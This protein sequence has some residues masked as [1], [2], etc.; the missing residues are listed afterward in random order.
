MGREKS[1]SSAFHFD[2]ALF[3]APR[4]YFSHFH[5]RLGRLS[6]V[7]FLKKEPPEERRGKK[8]G[9]CNRMKLS[10]KSRRSGCKVGARSR[11]RDSPYGNCK[12][13]PGGRG[14]SEG[15]LWRL[16]RCRFERGLSSSSTS[17]ID[18]AAHFSFFFQALCHSE[19]GQ[20]RRCGGERLLHE[21]KSK[22]FQGKKCFF[23][24]NRIPVRMY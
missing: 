14:G 10:R 8:E 15:S 5:Q 19:A 6:N 20:R 16:L 22:P 24:P 21:L 18:C 11:R 2:E 9:S 7:F 23:H 17:D 4:I 12:K 13:F 3:L 1:P